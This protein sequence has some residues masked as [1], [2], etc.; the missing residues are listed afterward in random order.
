MA[1]IAPVVWYPE[2]Y[3]P[4]YYYYPGYYDYCAAPYLLPHYDYRGADIHQLTP[5]F[6][7]HQ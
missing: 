1:Y 6:D 7:Y 3:Y 5:H 4:A 2:Y